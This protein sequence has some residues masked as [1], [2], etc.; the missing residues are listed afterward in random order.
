MSDSAPLNL[1]ELIIKSKDDK[2]LS[3]LADQV[4][5]LECQN[6]IIE[7]ADKQI[8]H[9]LLTFENEIKNFD[10]DE[11]NKI[12]HVSDKL[13]PH[14]FLKPGTFRK[15]IVYTRDIKFI[16]DFVEKEIRDRN[17]KYKKKIYKAAKDIIVNSATYEALRKKLYSQELIC[18]IVIDLDDPRYSTYVMSL[19]IFRRDNEFYF[20]NKQEPSK[21]MSYYDWFTEYHGID[22][23][24][25][26]K[27]K[28]KCKIFDNKGRLCLKPY[29]FK[30]SILNHKRHALD[31]TIAGTI[32][33]FSDNI[34]ND[35]NLIKALIYEKDYHNKDKDIM[36]N[37][38]YAREWETF[39]WN[40]WMAI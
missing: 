4:L 8:Q 11:L 23:C 5:T 38:F 19:D 10:I 30:D 29:S 2:Q 9:L 1:I 18:K 27:D 32:I 14:L 17:L 40:V 37:D 31:M 12:Y 35:N 6:Q 28:T 15:E 13:S 26:N 24:Y 3:K 39:P 34:M 33:K 16:D 7:R 21:Q 36:P 25:F 22:K 20:P